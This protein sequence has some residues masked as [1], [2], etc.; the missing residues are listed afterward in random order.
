M[1]W[2]TIVQQ[3]GNYLATSALTTILTSII[4]VLVGT[5]GHQETENYLM[6]T[7]TKILGAD[8]IIF[9]MVRQICLF[10][11]VAVLHCWPGCHQDRNRSTSTGWPKVL[12]CSSPGFSRKSMPTSIC[13]FLRRLPALEHIWVHLVHFHPKG[14]AHLNDECMI[15]QCWMNVRNEWANAGPS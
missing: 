11:V 13:C 7:A 6:T 8:D 3:E 12:L 10:I 5:D 2:S 4:Y 9:T 1:F 15:E 14:S